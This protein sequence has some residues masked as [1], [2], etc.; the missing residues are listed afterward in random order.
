MI[1]T[2]YISIQKGPND[3][4]Y[5]IVVMSWDHTQEAYLVIWT[6]GESHGEKNNALLDA[7]NES[8]KRGLEIRL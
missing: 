6:G 2:P 4:L 8:K 1:N 7:V 5:R 3:D